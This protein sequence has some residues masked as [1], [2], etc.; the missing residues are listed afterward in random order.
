MN[1]KSVS[2]AITISLQIAVLAG[3]I[4]FGGETRGWA[5]SATVLPPPAQAPGATAPKHSPR[6]QPAPRPTL[7]AV[8]AL[9]LPQH[10]ETDRK[11]ISTQLD[12]LIRDALE[13]NP[14]LVARRE[15]TRAAA[16][17]ILPA[18]MPADPQFGYRM[19]DMPTTFSFTRENAT[20]KQIVAHATYPFPGKL[21]LAREV[22]R[23]Q[24]NVAREEFDTQAQ[25]LVTQVRS[26]FADVFIADKDIELAM[27]HR[28]RLRDFVEIATAKYRVG[29]GLQ[30]DVLNADVAVASVDSQLIGLARRRLSR[31]I[32]VATLL[33]RDQVEILP[34]GA[35]PELEL[36]HSEL[37]L[38]QIAQATNPFILR[39]VKAVER[40]QQALALARKSA[41]PDFAVQVEY[42]SRNDFTHPETGRPDTVRPD[43]LSGQ[44]LMTVPV[45]YYSKQREQIDEA[46]A[47]LARSRARL[48]AARRAVLDT[49]HDLIARL[50]QHQQVAAAFRHEVIPL[51]SSAV[52]ASIS[53]YQVDRVDFL[54]LLAAQDKLDDYRARYW[55]EAAE[56]FRDTA[57]IE[58]VAGLVM[59]EG[60]WTR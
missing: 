29:P 46:A 57:Q 14:D 52:A 4:I 34:L 47:N 26:A 9:Q 42:G 33:D 39:A 17:R 50:H 56:V 35:L 28:A 53:A 5:G 37:E 8:P 13:V 15:Q 60:G 30:Q 11:V 43:L 54:T 51:A 48:A 44:I 18:G 23:G 40:D 32:V 49:L 36:K 22:A 45:F 7:P 31:Q 55:R 21:T 24:A 25:H 2:S 58:E 38:A 19:K 27:E 16:D 3:A 10:F 59:S 6:V 12:R 20:E 41:L 1:S